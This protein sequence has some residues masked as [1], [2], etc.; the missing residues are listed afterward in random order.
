[1]NK[2]LTFIVLAYKELKTLEDCVKSLK[3]QTINCRIVISTSTPNQ[4]VKKIAKKYQVELIISARIDEYNDVINAYNIANTKYVT[5]CHQDDVYLKD[6]AE[7]ILKIAHKYKKPLILFTNYYNYKNDVII[8]KSKML[9]IKRRINFILKFK[10][11]NSKKF[12]KKRS[13]SLGNAICSPSV[14]FNKSILKVPVIP[15]NNTTSWDWNTWLEFSKLKGAFVYIGRPLL[16]RRIHSLSESS[17]AITNS[18]RSKTDYKM[19]KK[20][21]PNI[22]AKILA[23]V[24]SSSEK[25]NQL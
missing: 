4:Y 5:L 16:L 14:C 15:G 10:I 12:I 6:Y 8:K 18:E 9:F 11:F 13:L 7:T 21:W 23:K 2:E 22:I 19:F 24:Y 3:A 20:F 1:M 25:E 17:A